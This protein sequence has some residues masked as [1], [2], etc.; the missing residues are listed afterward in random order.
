[1]TT[2]H[3]SHR[4][5]STLRERMIEDM[6]VRGFTEKTRNDYVRNMPASASRPLWRRR[7]ICAGFPAATDADQHA[8]A[9]GR[10][11]R[12]GGR[13]F[14]SRRRRDRTARRRSPLRPVVYD[15]PFRAASET[16]ITI[17]ADP[18]HLGA[19]IGVFSAAQIK[20]LTTY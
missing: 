19:R 14:C 6:T 17:A 1:M 16:L 2:S 12:R 18:R 11:E 10:A 8:P 3:P 9:A 4:P 20:P 15:L 5:V 7:R 13:R